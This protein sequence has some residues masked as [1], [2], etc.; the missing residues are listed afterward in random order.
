MW[1]LKKQKELIISEIKE[2]VGSE[3]VICA[4]SGGVD[5]TVVAYFSKSIGKNYT[6]LLTMDC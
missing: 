2:K 5:S 3:K 1:S 4:L 6:Y